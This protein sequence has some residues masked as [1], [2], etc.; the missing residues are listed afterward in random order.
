M[1]SMK[2]SMECLGTV[3]M[4]GPASHRIRISKLQNVVDIDW[5]P[6]AGLDDDSDSNEVHRRLKSTSML[7]EELKVGLASTS[8]NCFSCQL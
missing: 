8:Q 4:A 2:D 5:A 3:L 6:G 7:F 1:A